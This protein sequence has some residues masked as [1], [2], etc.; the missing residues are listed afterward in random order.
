M[1]RPGCLWVGSWPGDELPGQGGD[2]DQ[3]VANTPCPHQIVTPCRPWCADDDCLAI[4]RHHKVT[5]GPLLSVRRA[6][7]GRQ[8]RMAVS[9]ASPYMLT[10]GAL[11]PLGQY[12]AIPAPG[13]CFGDITCHLGGPGP[14]G[15]Q[16]LIDSCDSAGG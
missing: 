12:Q 14:V 10:A 4:R 3:V 2:L 15:G 9:R 6:G 13:Q 7:T 1:G 5:A 11:S 16:V 8:L